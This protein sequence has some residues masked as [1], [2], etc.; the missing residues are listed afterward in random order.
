MQHDWTM[1]YQEEVKSDRKI[2]LPPEVHT[3]VGDDHEVHGHSVYWNYERN[4]D[5]IV[6]SQYALREPNYGDVTRTK[7]YGAEHGEETT[8]YIRIP[9]GLS[10]LVRSNYLE[11]TRVNYMAYREML[12]GDNPT[13]FLLS[14]AQFQR[15]LPSGVR[16]SVDGDREGADDRELEESL[17]NLPAF[18]P[19]P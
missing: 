18:L 1:F 15:L 4:A 11:G 19:S 13:V 2:P 9:E 14:N 3:V 5:Y 8:G 7:V 10:D 17:M 16:A 6:L 12:A